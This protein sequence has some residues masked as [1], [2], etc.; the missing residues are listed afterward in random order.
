MKRIQKARVKFITLCPR[1]KNLMPVLY[2]ADGTVAFDALTKASEDA[3][4]LTNIV[5][6]AERADTDDHLASAEVIKDMA[7][8]FQKEGGQIDIR[9]DGKPVS[10]DKAYVA[11]SFIVQKGDPRF[12]DYTDYDGNSVDATGA[13]ATVIKIEDPELRR[14]YREGEWNG[15][16]M[17]GQGLLTVEKADEEK[18]PHWFTKFLTAVGLGSNSNNDE[19]V[20]MKKQEL[21]EVFE[22]QFE[23]LAEILKPA[24]KADETEEVKKADEKEE[25]KK[26]EVK[27]DLTDPKAVREHA[28]KLEK[29]EALKNLDL[30]DP[31]AVR[32]HLAKLEKEEADAIEKAEADDSD[33][34][35]ELKAKLRKAE[36]KAGTKQAGDSNEK[37][38]V[39][40]GFSKEET[41]AIK[42]G[43]KMAAFNNKEHGFTA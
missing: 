23:K 18:P 30:T 20:D 4:E 37:D 43:S 6:P 5:Y 36:I 38:E 2:K 33:E 29:E 28:E 3:G 31:K 21:E 15:V 26:E 39:I 17:Q 9:H 7:H 27:L 25:V 1:G 35:K 19:D 32:E 24:P 10:K 14:L 12:E 16:S 40:D 13:W 42:T 41:S 22:K 34:V 11:E 8:A